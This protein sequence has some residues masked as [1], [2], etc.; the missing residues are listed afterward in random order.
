V[1]RSRVIPS[2]PKHICTRTNSPSQTTPKRPLKTD[3]KT[4]DYT[5]NRNFKPEITSRPH[6]PHNETSQRKP[7]AHNS[8]TSTT[9]KIFS[10]H[11]IIHRLL[12]S[13]LVR[14][15][16]NSVRSLVGRPSSLVMID[17]RSLVASRRLEG[18][19]CNLN[20]LRT[21]FKY[22]VKNPTACFQPTA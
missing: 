6:R 9:T 3:P 20:N 22:H 21:T 19:G 7:T 16:R 18:I 10:P 8:T 13:E 12:P 4:F 1:E 2:L 5:Q 14:K 15:P 17:D 11:D